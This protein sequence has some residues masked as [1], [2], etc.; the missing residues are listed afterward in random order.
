M[1]KEIMK[2]FTGLRWPSLVR[3]AG[4]VKLGLV[5]LAG[6]TLSVAH[7]Q[8][9][10]DNFANA[11]VLTGDWGSMNVDNNLATHESGEPSHAGCPAN[12]S[13]WYQWTAPSDGEVTLDTIGS[14]NVDT[15]LAVYTG[16][17]LATLSQVAAN[18]DLYPVKSSSK[19][20][21]GNTQ[22]YNESGSGDYAQIVS[23]G[24]LPV[25]GYQQPYTGPSRLRFNARVG[26]TYYFAGDTKGLISGGVIFS[27]G[28]TSLS[29]AYKSSGVFRFATE[30]KDFS[31]DMPLYQCAQTESLPPMGLNISAN[32][33]IFT[34][35]NYNAPGV[36]VTVTRVAGSS[37]RVTVNYT[38][39]DG[40]SLPSIPSGDMPA[41]AGTDYTPVGGTLVFDDFEMSKTILV[42]IIYGGPIAGDQTNRVFG[43]QLL[44]DGGVTT[45]ARDYLESGAVSQPRVDPQFSTAMIKILNVNADPYGPDMISVVSTNAQ[46][47]WLD[48]PTDSIP[49]L[50]TNLV[51]ADFP[52]NAIFNFEK[53]NYRVPADVNNTNSSWTQVTLWV[54][55][56]GTNTE[57]AT[58]NY[59]VNNF[60][61]DDQDAAEEGNAYFPLQPGSDYAVPTPPT[62][63][64]WRGKNSD[65]NMTQGTISF[66]KDGPGSLYQPI[67]FTVPT[68][69]LT[70]FNRDF[71]I[72]L[73][74]ISSIGGNNG[75]GLT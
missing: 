65:F 21:P 20:P 72:Q 4:L 71:R 52:T 17:S 50:E 28:S 2:K 11:T 68:N 30:D 26:T 16:T 45:P 42:P 35:Y 75:P 25:L 40:T 18:D 32:S 12:A 51:L 55:R 27:G 49:N 9:A 48:P 69:K 34:Y 59:R 63:T 15:V 22:Q 70:K 33:A 56:F 73:N 57:A 24:G 13:V 6:L 64:V 74:R 31:T 19:V 10:N 67:T 54:E 60:L 8:P 37:R 61:G 23:P 46:D 47:P 43:I 66:P 3:S 53:A 44:D 1:I 62:N 39:V 58:L 29:W 38:N 14:N 36:L 7:A 5:V 41:I